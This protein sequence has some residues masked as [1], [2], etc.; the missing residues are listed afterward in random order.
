MTQWVST[1]A[2]AIVLLGSATPA[3]ADCFFGVFCGGGNDG[4]WWGNGGWWN[5]GDG[6]GGFDSSHEVSV[7]EPLTLLTVGAGLAGAAWLR[8]RRR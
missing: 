6:D 5:N 3:R 8:R 7:P 4:G 1:L 2:L